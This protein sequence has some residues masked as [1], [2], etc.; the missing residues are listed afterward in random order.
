[1]EFAA[2]KGSDGMSGEVPGTRER[3]PSG[4]ELMAG[5]SSRHIMMA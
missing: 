1:M 2:L 4:I 3:R 5:E